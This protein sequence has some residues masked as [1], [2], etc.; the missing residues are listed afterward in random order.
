MR[1]S[2]ELGEL[3]LYANKKDKANFLQI[4]AKIN[5]VLMLI[6]YSLGE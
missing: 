5:K 6:S 2:N 1:N 3:R 4:T